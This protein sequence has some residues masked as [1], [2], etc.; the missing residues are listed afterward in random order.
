[1]DHD[2]RSILVWNN[3]RT[4][5]GVFHPTNPNDRPRRIP[6]QPTS[7][8]PAMQL[9][10][11]PTQDRLQLVDNFISLVD[12]PAV[13]ESIYNLDEVLRRTELSDIACNY[14]KGQPEVAAI[15]KDRYLGPAIDLE[16]LL[17]LP[18]A[19]LGYQYALHLKVNQFQPLFY[20]QKDFSDE[21]SYLTLRRSQSHDI[22]HVVTGFGADLAGEV[23]LQAFGLAQTR[24]PLAVPLIASAMMHA[25]NSP[26]LLSDIMAQMHH[27]WEMGLRAK[28]FMAQKWEENW[29]KPVSQ[30]REELQVDHPWMGATALRS[31]F[32][33]M[34]QLPI[35]A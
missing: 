30:W 6:L 29:E 23:G 20:R 15:I 10:D 3:S 7:N 5:Q 16:H 17:S 9:K 13:F 34:T 18:K 12:H 14:L 35:A 22:H 4:G 2:R 8:F 1:M 27:G 31:C 11:I 21:I 26:A 28:P 19:S 33:M 24:S 32:S 25:H